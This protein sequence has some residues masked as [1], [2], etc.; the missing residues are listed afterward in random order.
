MNILSKEIPHV[1][2]GRVVQSVARL[3]QEPE[4]QVRYLVWPH[5]FVSPSAD[6]RRA[7]ANLC[8]RSIGKPL[9]RS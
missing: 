5:T 4:V 8:A 7:L 3:T 1:M 2:P 6:S 9:K